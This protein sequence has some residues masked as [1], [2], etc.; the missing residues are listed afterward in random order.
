M[1]PE[2]RLRYWV[3]TQARY[4]RA[5]TSSA[6]AIAAGGGEIRNKNLETV[7]SN[8]LSDVVKIRKQWGYTQKRRKG[9]AVILFIKELFVEHLGVVDKRLS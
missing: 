8:R 5:W 1:V 9:D 6:L 2:V 4:V 7:I 3:S